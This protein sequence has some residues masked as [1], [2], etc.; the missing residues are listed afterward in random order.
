M[1]KAGH[2]G[3]IL[4]K[5]EIFVKISSI[6]ERK[7]SAKNGT[8]GFYEYHFATPI[9][10]CFLRPRSIVRN[11]HMRS[12]LQPTYYMPHPGPMLKFS[13][14]PLCNPYVPTVP[15][16]AELFRFSIELIFT[17][18]SFYIKF[19]HNGPL[20][21]KNSMNNTFYCVRPCPANSTSRPLLSLHKL[22]YDRGA[23]LFEI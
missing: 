7:S 15:F 4:C 22:M 6:E 20:F 2:Y 11:R 10:I 19:I 21:K 18:I 14:L 16:L 23:E 9:N 8:V 3:E 17:N 12:S 1:I 13:W 5:N